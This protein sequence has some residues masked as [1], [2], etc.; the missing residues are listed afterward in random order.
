MHLRVFAMAPPGTRAEDCARLAAAAAGRA[1]LLVERPLDQAG[2]LPQ[3][4]ARGT[5]LWADGAS[6]RTL[7]RW[8]LGAF[9]LR[10]MRVRVAALDGPGA[11]LVLDGPG[12]SPARIG[13]LRTLCELLGKA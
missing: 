4:C 8:W 11:M 9:D 12:A 1:T 13:E 6:D 10:E 5:D 3:W 7:A 2:G